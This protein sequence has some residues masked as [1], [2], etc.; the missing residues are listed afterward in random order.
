MAARC[1]ASDHG[2]GVYLNVLDTVW[3][4]PPGPTYYIILLPV[5]PGSSWQRGVS[6]GC[7]VPGS[8]TSC[9]LLVLR[10]SAVCHPATGPGPVL[11]SGY[12]AVPTPVSDFLISG[13]FNEILFC[14]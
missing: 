2:S 9:F 6:S 11:N 8:Q 10:G 14:A 13:V 12:G 3:G 5:P 4:L 1:L 7:E